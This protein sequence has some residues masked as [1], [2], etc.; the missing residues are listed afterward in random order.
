M[1]QPNKLCNVYILTHFLSLS[2]HYELK[3]NIEQPLNMMSVSL[4]INTVF[5]HS[6]YL[7]YEVNLVKKNYRNLKY[8]LNK[9]NE[10]I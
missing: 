2:R 9:N 3:L 8:G 4:E 1:C 10:L 7:F 6:V 5:I